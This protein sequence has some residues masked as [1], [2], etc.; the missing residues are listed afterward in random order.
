MALDPQLQPIIDLIGGAIP[1]EDKTPAEVRAMFGAAVVPLD[2]TGLASAD[3]ITVGGAEGDL[4]ARVYRPAEA[5]GNGPVIVFFHG[6]G[7]V[8]GSI[9][10]HDNTAGRLAAETG[11]TVVSVEYRLAPEHKFPA[12]LE[13]AYAATAWVAEHAGDLGVDASRLAVAGDSAGGNLAAAV[14]LLARERGGPALAYQLLIYPV[15]DITF[16][17]PSHAENGPLNYILSEGA[18]RWFTEH[19][20]GGVGG[21]DW[22]A[23]PI[24]A[25]LA[26][27]PPAY[28]V[29]AELDP[30]RDEGVAYAEKLRA[31]GVPADHIQGAGMCHGFYGFPADESL[32]VRKE[33]AT[34]VREVLKP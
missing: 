9:Q 28:V 1:V 3:D 26:G 34:A 13:D 22:R 29:T 15:T 21:A 16:D 33:V 4:P 17:Y 32:R 12:P 31:A 18:M 6:G 25:D 19:Y 11:C 20:I 30:L 8:I 24:Q 27:L 5:A 2:M 23:A 14:C 10:S 7:W